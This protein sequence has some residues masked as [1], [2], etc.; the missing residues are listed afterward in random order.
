MASVAGILAEF[1]ARAVYLPPYS[2][3]FNPSSKPSRSVKAELRRREMRTIESLWPAFGASLDRVIA[4]QAH[5]Y[6]QHA[7]YLLD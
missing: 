5:N 6:F 2:P 1:Q 4:D 7:G 3:D